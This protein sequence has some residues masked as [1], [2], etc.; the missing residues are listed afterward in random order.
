MGPGERGALLTDPVGCFRWGINFTMLLGNHSVCVFSLNP[1]S[2]IVFI[3]S[4]MFAETTCPVFLLFSFV[5]DV[6]E[7]RA[8]LYLPSATSER[9]CGIVH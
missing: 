1:I 2:L 4:S 9:H 5:K 6:D 8:S 3:C 7:L